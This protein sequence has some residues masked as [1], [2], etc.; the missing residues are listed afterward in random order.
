MDLMNRYLTD[1]NDW[2]ETCL[3]QRNKALG[4]EHVPSSLVPLLKHLRFDESSRIA[5]LAVHMGVSRR[6]VSQIAAEGVALGLLEMVAD[7]NDAR[8]SLVRLSGH[9]FEVCRQAI[10]NMRTIETELAKRIGREN[11]ALLVAI[12]K[13]DWGPPELAEDS[14]Q[15]L[16]TSLKHRQET[17]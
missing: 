17:Q 3:K 10:E 16:R 8:V 11:V 14:P 6:R 7:P 1:K 9:G 4:Q 5:L 2:Y 12:L 15:L 13:M